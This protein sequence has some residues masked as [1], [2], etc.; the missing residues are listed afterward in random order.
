MA[1]QLPRTKPSV[2]CGLLLLEDLGGPII[3]RHEFNKYVVFIIDEYSIVR[4]SRR[5]R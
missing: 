4:P 2:L 1:Y 3:E 5:R